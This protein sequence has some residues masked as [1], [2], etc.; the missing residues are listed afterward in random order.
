MREM[1]SGY[2]SGE[3]SSSRLHTI[4]GRLRVDGDKPSLVE[5][6][7]VVFDSVC[8]AGEGRLAPRKLVKLVVEILDEH[9]GDVLDGFGLAPLLAILLIRSRQANTVCVQL[10]EGGR[11]GVT[12][13]AVGKLG[14][15]LLPRQSLLDRAALGRHPVQ[16]LEDHAGGLGQVHGVEVQVRNASRQDLAA[17][18]SDE[19]LANFSSGGIVVLDGL[20]GIHELLGDPALHMV[21]PPEKTGV[22]GD[23]HDAW[24]DGNVDATGSDLANPAEKVVDVV[25]HL[26]DDEGGTGVHLLLQVVQQLLLVLVVVATL[27]VPG[28]ANVEVIVVRLAY[29]DDQILCVPETVIG[30]LPL[31]LVPWRVTSQ[32]QYVGATS[33]VCFAQS[34]VDL[35]EPH[36]GAG[37][38]HTRLETEV[39]LGLADHLACQL[40][41]ATAGAPGDVDELWA[42]VVHALHTVVEVLHAGQCFR[43]EVFERERRGGRLL[44]IGNHLLDVHLEGGDDGVVES[45]VCGSKRVE[46]S[47]RATRN[48]L[49]GLVYQRRCQRTGRLGVFRRATRWEI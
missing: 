14:E 3:T 12:P 39:G 43:R 47:S 32:C 21:D 1:S 10:A 4:D 31:L 15:R 33:L 30:S 19:G 49:E 24:N 16:L 44:G 27:R 23:G 48:R 2:T 38:V 25:E 37:E 17:H 36:I 6:D 42:K 22:C 35:L 5:L 45:N 8:L 26:G 29:M 46:K 34:V 11:P 20:Q 9:G 7:E 13:T 18:V 41:Y 40:G 28:N